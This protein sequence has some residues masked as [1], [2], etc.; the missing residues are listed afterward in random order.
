MPPKKVV[1]KVVEPVVEPVVQESE[2]EV[3]V[4]VDAEPDVLQNITK[5]V[6]DIMTL[7]KDLQAQIKVLQKEYTK[8]QKLTAKKPSSQR[9]NP[10]GFAKPTKLSKELCEFLSLPDDTE[11]ARTAVT[12]HIN[13]YIMEH[14]LQNP[15]NKKLIL[16][17]EKLTKLLNLQPTD[18]QLSYFNLQRYMK[19]LFV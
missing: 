5:K 15:E 13:A 6:G 3:V 11:L 14:N 19:H 7:A 4:S 9:K 18:Q 1:Q 10:S 2:P 12:K 17:D 8:M 16:A